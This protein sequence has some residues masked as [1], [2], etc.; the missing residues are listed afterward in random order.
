MNRPHPAKNDHAT[1]HPDRLEERL[2]AAKHPMDLPD[3]AYE[4][5]GL[6]IRDPRLPH[7]LVRALLDVASALRDEAQRRSGR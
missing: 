2:P 6:V 3:L 4:C 7:A 5:E 1:T